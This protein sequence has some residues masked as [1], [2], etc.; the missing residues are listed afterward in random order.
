[1]VNHPTPRNAFKPDAFLE[2]MQK[3]LV[4]AEVDHLDRRCALLPHFSQLGRFRSAGDRHNFRVLLTSGEL[5]YQLF[6]RF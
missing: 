2:W 5:F 1:M 3:L 4:Q 6:D